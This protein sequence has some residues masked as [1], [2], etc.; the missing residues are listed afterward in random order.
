[1]SEEL[2]VKRGE[3]EG[4]I[5]YLERMLAAI[6]EGLEL[7]GIT[8]ALRTDQDNTILTSLGKSP[9]LKVVDQD[10]WDEYWGR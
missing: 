9:H 4:N 7:K 10:E 3:E 5:K 2:S 8:I 6:M 1:M